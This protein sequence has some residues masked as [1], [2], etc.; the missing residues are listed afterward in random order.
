[1]QDVDDSADDWADAGERR[2]ELSMDEHQVG[3][4]AE[5]LDHFAG[6]GE[7][8]QVLERLL[9]S[10]DPARA[11]AAEVG[12]SAQFE[13]L[14]KAKRTCYATPQGRKEPDAA[15]VGVPELDQTLRF[16]EQFRRFFHPRLAKRAAGFATIFD[17]LAQH[18]RPLIVETGCLRIPGNWE[19]DGQSSFM[20]DALVRARNGLFFSI[21][22]L[23]ESIETARRAL[24]SAANLICN[25][26]VAALHALSRVV[27]GAAS[28]LYLDSF[29][30]DLADPM[31]SAIHHIL[32]LTAARPL[33]GPGTIVCVD[34]YEVLGEQGGKG[35][36][37]DQFFS[38]IRAEVLHSG[39][40]K[41]WAMP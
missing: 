30:L 5:L 22:A 14:Y 17:A 21:D 20:F 27:N 25:D 13:R 16:S 32:E 6:P 33:I 15:L 38:A 40:Q 10:T 35:L 1:M 3:R 26:S 36:I 29:D 9:T 12:G 19:G 28:L 41:V 7:G 23:P 34:D 2:A 24:S 31:P 4:V 18:Q 11:I 39:Y 37:L 8:R